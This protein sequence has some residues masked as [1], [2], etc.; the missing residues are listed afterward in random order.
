VDV[1]EEEE[2]EEVGDVAVVATG[3]STKEVSTK[4][5][6]TKADSTRVDSTRVEILTKVAI[7]TKED[8]TKVLPLPLALLVPHKEAVVD[9]VDED[10]VAGAVVASVEAVEDRVVFPRMLKS[11]QPF[12]PAALL[13]N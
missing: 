9:S 6:S 7:S 2:E 10:V 13:D 12:Y 11:D 8:S 1:V 4:V 5:D 3:V